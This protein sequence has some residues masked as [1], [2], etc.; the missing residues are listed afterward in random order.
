MEEEE[1]LQS[2]VSCKPRQEGEKEGSTVSMPPD[3]KKSHCYIIYRGIQSTCKSNTIFVAV[4]YKD[5][6]TLIH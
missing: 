6:Y 5:N 2:V 4:A 3:G 1:D